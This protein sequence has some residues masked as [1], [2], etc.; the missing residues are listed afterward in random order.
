MVDEL[1]LQYLGVLPA[2]SDDTEE[3]EEEQA[4]VSS[5]YTGGWSLPP[6][7]VRPPAPKPSNTGGWSLPPPPVRPPASTPSNTGG[8]SLPPPPRYDPRPDVSQTERP[9]DDSDSDSARTGRIVEELQDQRPDYSDDY[10]QAIEDAYKNENGIYFQLYMNQGIVRKNDFAESG[11]DEES[12]WHAQIHVEKYMEEM[13]LHYAGQ[14]ELWK[15]LALGATE[16]TR[17]D[18]SNDRLESAVAVNIVTK[19]QIFRRFGDEDETPLQ[20]ESREMIKDPHNTALVHNHWNDSPGSQADFDAALWLGVRYLIVVTPSGMQ[21]IYERDGDA[22]KLVDEI[23]NREHVAL[24]SPA[25]TAESR[26]AYEAQTL[27]EAGNP[28]ERVMRQ[29]NSLDTAWEQANDA[30]NT[31]D[32]HESFENYK[33]EVESAYGVRFTSADNADAWNVDRV[34]L[35][36]EGLE[37]MAMALG[38]WARHNGY[39]W[40]NAEAFRRIIGEIELRHS[41]EVS[42]AQAQVNAR[43]ITIF[44]KAGSDRNYYLLPNVLLHE[45]GHVLNANAGLG[46]RNDPGSINYFAEITD[47]KHAFEIYARTGNLIRAYPGTREGMGAPR[48][49]LLRTDDLNTYHVYDDSMTS[50]TPLHV[51]VEMAANHALF[52]RTGLNAMQIQYLQYSTDPSINEITADSIVNWVH[53]QN[54]GGMFGYTDTPGGLMWQWFMDTEE[55]KIMRNAIVHNAIQSGDATYASQIE[56]LPEV[57]GSGTVQAPSGVNVRSAPSR[58]VPTIGKSRQFGENFL[59]LGRSSDK[60]WIATARNGELGWMYYGPENADDNGRIIRLPE[61]VSI[62]DLPEVPDDAELDFDPNSPVTKRD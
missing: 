5:P 47:S 56:E 6:P 21:Y 15:G 52:A 18:L 61:G 38:N 50:L 59:V 30:Y 22:M 14:D 45:L 31:G 27:A 41:R 26:A 49:D 39:N 36:Q 16:H 28:A 20:E 17:K 8:W 54:T 1:Y 37:E 19:E 55:D 2:P 51:D 53:H 34:K 12:D 46:D 44:W 40:D 42:K 35:I 4:S 3:P 23:F 62:T 13:K 29:E 24:P 32:E 7:P 11:L 10:G 25:E 43:T 33:T 58:V 48:P 57:F 60:E 9:L